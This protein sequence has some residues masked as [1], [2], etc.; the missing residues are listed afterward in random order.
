MDHGGRTLHFPKNF[1]P[2]FDNIHFN[3]MY[4]VF[5]IIIINNNYKYNNNSCYF[6]FW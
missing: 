1:T 5:I 2:N 6:S 3:K 4:L